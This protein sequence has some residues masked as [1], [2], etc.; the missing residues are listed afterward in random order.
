MQ[1][2]FRKLM[3]GM[4][5]AV[6]LVVAHAAEAQ[7]RLRGT[8]EKV[9]AKTVVVKARDGSVV[10]LAF[11]DGVRVDEVLPVD[12]GAIQ[13]GTFVGTT[14]VP[15]G[16]GSLSAVEVHVFPESARGTGE[17]HRP[18]D[19]QPNSTMTNATVE[20]ITPGSN[21]R[22]LTLRYKDGE[23]TIR[24][25]N[26]VPIVTMK[27]GNRSLLVPGAKVIVFE[28]V[29][30]GQPVAARILVGRDGFEPPM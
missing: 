29:V 8:I 27:P 5:I 2:T 21:D 22:T 13:E 7:V 19:L 18:W 26:G 25:P 12:P 28:Q 9:D 10:P 14:A 6:A 16:D 11:A 4:A 3:T 17:G 20:K 23:Q 24:V 15:R 1:R 30:N